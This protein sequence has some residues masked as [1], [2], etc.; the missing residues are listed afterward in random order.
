M[1]PLLYVEASDKAAELRF[2]LD[3]LNQSSDSDKMQT[4]ED[5]ARYL[6]LQ[7]Q[8]RRPEEAEAIC[9]GNSGVILKDLTEYLDRQ[10]RIADGRYGC[11]ARNNSKAVE[12][13]T[14]QLQYATSEHGRIYPRAS[15]HA[16]WHNNEAPSECNLCHRLQIPLLLG[17][18]N[19]LRGR[20]LNYDKK[21]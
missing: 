7:L 20:A 2:I 4:L 6:S 10:S 11:L 21:R 15:R 8:S 18:P 9:R 16:T 14:R 3:H 5:N 17:F 12:L 19:S 1:R 13:S